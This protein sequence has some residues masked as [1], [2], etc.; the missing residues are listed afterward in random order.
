MPVAVRPSICRTFVCN[1][2]GTM[3]GL[4]GQCNRTIN[5][6]AGGVFCV[7]AKYGCSTNVL[8]WLFPHVNTACTILIF[9]TVS[10]HWLISI[11]MT[12]E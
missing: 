3:E 6:I 1:N 11:M 9:V 2:N 5:Y 7:G 10:Q 8:Y 12:Y 4:L